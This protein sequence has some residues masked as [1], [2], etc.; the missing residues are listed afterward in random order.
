M[1]QNE[2]LGHIY[3]HIN[4]SPVQMWLPIVNNA[5]ITTIKVLPENVKKKKKVQDLIRC[6]EIKKLASKIIICVV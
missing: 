4:M 1:G 3:E 6:P 5:Y 2:L